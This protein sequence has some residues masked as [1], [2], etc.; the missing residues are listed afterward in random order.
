MRT[1]TSAGKGFKQRRRDGSLT[2]LPPFPFPAQGPAALRPTPRPSARRS[3]RDHR[4][5]A[6]PPVQVGLRRRRLPVRGQHRVAAGPGP[7]RSP[8][9]P[10]RAATRPAG[11]GRVTRRRGTGPGRGGEALGSGRGCRA[12]V[13]G[14]RGAR[15]GGR[16]PGPLLPGGPGGPWRRMLGQRR[17]ARRRAE[18]SGAGS[19]PR[20]VALPLP[21]ARCPLPFPFCPLSERLG[22]FIGV[23]AAGDVSPCLK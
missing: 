14:E 17:A 16:R 3:A 7:G 12:A 9:V 19:E 20:R 11:H 13:A 4:S 21:G 15:G 1:S 6:G 2:N 18:R 10:R 5:T 22:G 23:P 8:R